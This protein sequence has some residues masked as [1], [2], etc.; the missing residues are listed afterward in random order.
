MDAGFGG[1]GRRHGWLAVKAGGKTGGRRERVGLNEEE[2]P[3]IMGTLCSGITP[4]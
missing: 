1:R 4:A 3:E 2:A